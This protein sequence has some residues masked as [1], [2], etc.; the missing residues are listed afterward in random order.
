M[1]HLCETVGMVPA[2]QLPISLVV[3]ARDEAAAIARCLDSVPF[4]AEKLV[5]DA[6]ST[7]GT[8]EIAR[9]HGARVI[10][11]DWLGFGAQR[12]FA[13][14]QSTYDWIIVLDADEA[15]SPQLIEELRQGLPAL[16]Q[17]THAGAILRR[18]TWYMG[19]RM[20]WY[21]PMVGE[22]LGRIYHRARARWTDVRVHESLRY[23]GTT[24][25]YR[26]PFIHLNNPT[27]VHKQLKTLRY[28]E[29]KARD[30]HDRDKP[31]QMALAPL[32]FISAFFKDYFLRLAFLDGWRG[33][34]VSQ[35]AAAYAVY[36]RMRYYEMKRNPESRE[37]AADL[38]HRY[39]LDP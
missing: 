8:V 22:Q 5:I 15:L 10:H 17:S 11:Q 19:A 23:E 13:T 30:W 28:A 36:K 4:A 39:G 33:Y 35:T 7:D 21:R 18:E 37:A 34:I 3:I 6:G 9:A 29:L 2:S 25:T 38:L 31:T 16:M 24:I 12:N 1:A 27:L 32:V 26:H 14:T 20:K